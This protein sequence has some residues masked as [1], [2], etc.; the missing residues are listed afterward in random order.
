MDRSFSP[1]I[2]SHHPEPHLFI[3]FTAGHHHHP[4]VHPYPHIPPGHKVCVTMVAELAAVFP[5]DPDPLAH[6]DP[7]GKR[8]I[9][10]APF[11]VFRKCLPRTQEQD[12]DPF[13]CH[14]LR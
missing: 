5:V 4:T 6:G 7:P 11:R 1:V 12:A 10:V 2:F 13:P 3:A 8:N 14:C 9:P